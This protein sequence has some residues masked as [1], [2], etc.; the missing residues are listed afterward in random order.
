[1]N[2]YDKSGL[3]MAKTDIIINDGE[4]EFTIKAIKILKFK[5]SNDFCFFMILQVFVGSLYPFHPHLTKQSID[6]FG[7]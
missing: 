2:K 6:P 5:M 4:H 7:Q 1:M 3:M